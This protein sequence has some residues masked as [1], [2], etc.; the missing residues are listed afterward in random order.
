MG[1]LK[2]TV[3]GSFPRPIELREAIEGAVGKQRDKIS[4][5]G[6]ETCYRAATGTVIGEQIEAGVGLVTDG[7]LRW[8]DFLAH[9]ALGLGGIEMDGLMR[10]FDNNVYYRIPLVVGRVT[11]KTDLLSRDFRTAKEVSGDVE[12]K[13]V[14]CGPYT[15][16]RLC[17]NRVDIEFSELVIQMAD[18]LNAEMRGLARQGASV[19]QV[20]EPSLVFE[21]EPHMEVAGEGFARMRRGISSEV[22]L[23]T[24]FG[25]I[26]H[27]KKRVVDFG[28][29]VLGIDA[30]ASPGV[31]ETEFAI[32]IAL[33]CVD[34]RNTKM[35]SS[36]E[37]TDVMERA[38]QRNDVPYVSPNCG[39]EFLPVSKAREKLKLL[40]RVARKV[41]K[42][43]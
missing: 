29:D 31:V 6:L 27:I 20:D 26:D 43:E 9:C 7:Q 42:D 23:C 25:P 28:E 2:V 17:R 34:A 15:L 1:Q 16:A 38:I 14:I 10:F 12:V 11:H 21:T 13:P 37:L 41:R 3:V 35:E 5:E 24:Y 18:A 8:D 4:D 32:P 22:I 19:I 30:A 36:S 40:S 33:G 39:L